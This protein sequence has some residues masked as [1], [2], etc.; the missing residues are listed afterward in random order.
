M[1][2]LPVKLKFISRKLFF[3]LYDK[4]RNYYLLIT[5]KNYITTDKYFIFRV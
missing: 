3:T 2:N 4:D 5:S 1:F